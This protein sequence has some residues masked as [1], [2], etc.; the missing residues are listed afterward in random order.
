MN[1]EVFNPDKVEENAEKSLNAMLNPER[2]RE[3]SIEK[4][5]EL[6]ACFKEEINKEFGPPDIVDENGAI[7]GNV[8]RKEK[9]RQEKLKGEWKEDSESDIEFEKRI[10]N[11]NSII[12]EKIVTIIFNKILGEDYLIFH[13]SRRDDNRGFDT[14]V[15]R[16]KTGE[17][18]CTIDEKFGKNRKLYNKKINEIERKNQ[19]NGGV[20]VKDGLTFRNEKLIKKSINRVP[21]FLLPISEN[22]FNK[23]LAKMNLNS[24]EEI[25]DVELEIFNKLIDSLNNQVKKLEGKNITTGAMKDNL[26][27]FENSLEKMEE[28]RKGFN[29]DE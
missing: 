24:M 6:L 5:D 7:I 14:V 11:E 2:K 16:R 23:V 26:K 15:I 4:I 19:Y 21:V 13:S 9:K 27:E 29:A 22:D 25:S 12:W 8:S 10:K 18:V 17:M 28:L 1:S 20:L 3:K